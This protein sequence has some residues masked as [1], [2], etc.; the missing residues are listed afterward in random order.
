MEQRTC[1]KQEIRCCH[2]TSFNVV[3]ARNN[4]QVLFS[5]SS[6]QFYKMS[7][8]KDHFPSVTQLQHGGAKIRAH[9]CL[10]PN[11]CDSSL[12]GWGT[13]SPKLPSV[14]WEENIPGSLTAKV[15]VH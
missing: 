7:H 9:I 2:T 6:S 4:L 10:T 12:L 14:Y 11:P 1:D 15:Q 5:P 3:D 13:V 8:R